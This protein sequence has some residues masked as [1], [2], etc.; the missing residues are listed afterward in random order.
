[1]GTS[2]CVIQAIG[3]VKL[4]KRVTLATDIFCVDGVLYS[5]METDVGLT[6]VYL[7]ESA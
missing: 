4:I 7:P 6:G 3:A 1:M 2:K 5:A